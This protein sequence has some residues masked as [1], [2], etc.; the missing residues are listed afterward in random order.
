MPTNS[1]QLDKCTYIGRFGPCGRP[2]FREVCG[3][4]T[5]KKPRALCV[6]CGVRGTASSTGYCMDEKSGCRWRN[7]YE[8]RVAKAAREARNDYIDEITSWDWG[9]THA[10]CQPTDVTQP[11]VVYATAGF[12]A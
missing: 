5:G 8:A 11:T 4:H 10:E 1:K 2:C 6:G 3:N 9:V 12:L 7:Q